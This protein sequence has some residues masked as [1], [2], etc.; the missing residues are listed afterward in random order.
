M[1]PQSLVLAIAL[2]AAVIALWVDVRF[3]RLAP[4][5]FR[6]AIMHVVAALVTAQAILM[7]GATDVIAGSPVTMMAA[8]MLVALPVLIYEFLAAVWIIKLAQ[9]M[10]R[11]YR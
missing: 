9:A 7:S 5:D 6:R 11:A 10:F 3:P 2:G 8:T 4:Q 1:T